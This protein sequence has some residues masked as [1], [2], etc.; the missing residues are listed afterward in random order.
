MNS[1]F[2]VNCKEIEEETMHSFSHELE[3]KVRVMLGLQ[4]VANYKLHLAIHGMLLI[5]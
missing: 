2:K 5:F 1:G 4:D 3:I